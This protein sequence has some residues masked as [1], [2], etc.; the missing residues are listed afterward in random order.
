M[1]TAQPTDAGAMLGAVLLLS[2]LDVATL[3]RTGVNAGFS[4]LGQLDG[5]KAVLHA[6]LTRHVQ[7][8]MKSDPSIDPANDIAKASWS[9]RSDDES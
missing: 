4:L 7:H 8:L 9:S 5:L 3:D 6:R 1:T 2:Q